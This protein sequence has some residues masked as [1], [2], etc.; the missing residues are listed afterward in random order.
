MCQNVTTHSNSPKTRHTQSRW[1]QSHRRYSMLGLII[2]LDTRVSPSLSMQHPH[3]YPA[4]V[5]LHL[6]STYTRCRARLNFAWQLFYATNLSAAITAATASHTPHTQQCAAD[7]KRGSHTTATDKRMTPQ[8]N[9]ASKRL[10]IW[11]QRT[12]V[13]LQKPSYCTQQ[14]DTRTLP[15]QNQ[16]GTANPCHPHP[17]IRSTGHW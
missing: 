17:Y 16:N 15:H 14:Q 6:V 13:T 1:I 5:Q 10:A 9:A 2:P 7:K 12:V 8:Q 11:P 3:K 4:K